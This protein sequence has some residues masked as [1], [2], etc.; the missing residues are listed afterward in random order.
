MLACSLYCS[1]MRPKHTQTQSRIAANGLPAIP[2]IMLYENMRIRVSTGG[3]PQPCRVLCTFGLA[4]CR[5]RG[6]KA[7]PPNLL[8]L[9]PLLLR[10]ATGSLSS[11][12]SSR[13]LPRLSRNGVL[14]VPRHNQFVIRLCHF[15]SSPTFPPQRKTH[16][17]VSSSRIHSTGLYCISCVCLCA[18]RF[19]QRSG[20]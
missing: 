7:C 11:A 20:V 2:T 18:F 3:D 19:A 17:N 5:G 8:L 15:G 12:P 10:S 4:G 14:L 9:L 13:R 6:R 16:R 1:H